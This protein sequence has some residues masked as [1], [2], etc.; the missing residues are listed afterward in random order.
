VRYDSEPL[1]GIWRR[2]VAGLLGALAPE[3][4]L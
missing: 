3:E 4:L 1:A 2:M